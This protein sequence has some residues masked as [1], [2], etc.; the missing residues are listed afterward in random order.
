MLCA[1]CCV[2]CAVCCVLCA[3]CCVLCAVCCVLC[4]VCC[5]L[6]AVCCV[7]RLRHV[8]L[9]NNNLSGT[10][11]QQLSVLTGL[12]YVLWVH[13]ASVCRKSLCHDA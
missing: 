8:D 2:L 5:V 13:A 3:V 11:P 4:A 12:T 6:C 9:S 7:S 1:V 10:I